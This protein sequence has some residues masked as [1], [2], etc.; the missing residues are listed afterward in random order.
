MRKTGERVLHEGR[1]FVFREK[2]FVNDAGQPVA[3]E[4]IT[5]RNSRHVASL[6]TRLVPSGRYVIL[7]Q[8]RQGLE[9]WVLGFPAGVVPD[10]ATDDAAV[11]AAVLR[12]LEEEAGYFGRIVGVSPPCPVNAGFSSDLF[13]VYEVEVDETDPRNARPEQ[14][15]EPAE[16]IRV[17]LVHPDDMAAFFAAKAA[18][19]VLMGAGLWTLFGLR[20]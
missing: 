10:T 18:E 12:E 8:W 16:E 4:C 17:H 11:E 7:E 14:R 3:W 13:H 1:W 19:G 9:G 6:V 5:R 15:L 2:T 20:R